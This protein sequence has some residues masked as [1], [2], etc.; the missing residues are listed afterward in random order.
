MEYRENLIHT[1]SKGK[2][3]LCESADIN[4]ATLNMW[5]ELIVH[6]PVRSLPIMHPW[7]CQLIPG[8]QKRQETRRR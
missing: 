8:R 7:S 6:G 2:V 1:L 4:T 5:L 3:L